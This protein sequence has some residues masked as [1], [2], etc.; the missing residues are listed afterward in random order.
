[1]RRPLSSPS[2]LQ[3]EAVMFF[4]AMASGVRGLGL[5]QAE[6]SPSILVGGDPGAPDLEGVAGHTEPPFPDRWRRQKLCS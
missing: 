5:F 2:M 6:S 3:A 1:M 4:W